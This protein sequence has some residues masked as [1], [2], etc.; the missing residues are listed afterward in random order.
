MLINY[1]TNKTEGLKGIKEIEDKVRQDVYKN[2]VT[3]A[4]SSS[5]KGDKRLSDVEKL[6]K[7]LQEK[8]LPEHVKDEVE[9]EIESLSSSQSQT[10]DVMVKY[11]ETILDIPW[12]NGTQDNTDI[13]RAE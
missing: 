13:K 2:T 10:K 5:S 6:R 12:N 1:L 9:K 3:R 4:T 8:D 11:L 7:K